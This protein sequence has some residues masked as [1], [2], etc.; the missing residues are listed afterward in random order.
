LDYIASQKPFMAKRYLANYLR[1]YRKSSGLTQAEAAY[2]IGINRSEL[3]HYE[4]GRREPSLRVVIALQV[5]YRIPIWRLFAGIYQMGVLATKRRLR[6]LEATL[7]KQNSTKTSKQLT[8][9]LG[10]ISGRLNM[11]PALL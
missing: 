11:S 8:Q 9:K 5:L 6:A 4:T 1:A 3:W 2:V 7:H 10:W